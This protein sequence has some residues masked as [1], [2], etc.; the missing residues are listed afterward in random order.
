ME[1]DCAPRSY[2]VLGVA[3]G[4]FEVLKCGGL[5]LIVMEVVPVCSGTEK[6]KSSCTGRYLNEALEKVRSSGLL[7]C[8]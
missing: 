6:R 1:G 3:I 2:M 4:H 8:L 5:H 7:V